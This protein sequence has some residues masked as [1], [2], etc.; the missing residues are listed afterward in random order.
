MAANL[1]KPLEAVEGGEAQKGFQPFA[2]LAR[3]RNVSAKP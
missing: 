3:G 2:Q 1:A